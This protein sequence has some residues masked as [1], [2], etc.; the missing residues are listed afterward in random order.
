MTGKATA[1][2]LIDEGFRA[3][4]F[5]AVAAFESDYLPAALLPAEL[6][7]RDSL[8]D[9]AYDSATPIAATTALKYA[10]AQIRRAETMHAAATLWRRRAVA[11]DS[12]AVGGLTGFEAAN[13]REYL[14]HADAAEALAREYLGDAASRLGVALADN[15]PGSEIS[16]GH[17]ETGRFP[18]A[19]TTAVVA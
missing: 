9:A 5:G 13:R 12:N 16:V 7:A 6:W 15:T 2:D 17:V 3:T 1:Q 10:A 14:G 18:V 8:G 11:V 4:Q 19:S